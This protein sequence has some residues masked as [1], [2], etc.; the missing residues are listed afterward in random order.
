MADRVGQHAAAYAGSPY[1]QWKNVTRNAWEWKQG[2]RALVEGNISEYNW[3]SWT[4]GQHFT[5]TTRRNSHTNWLNEAIAGINPAGI[6]TLS[7]PSFIRTGD[8]VRIRDTSNMDHNYKLGKVTAGCDLAAC[9]S[10][11]VSDLP[12]SNSTGGYI[13][14]VWANRGLQDINIRWN[15]LRHSTDVVRMLSYE[16]V[17]TERTT[18]YLRR[19]AL[20]DNLIYDQDTSSYANGGWNTPDGKYAGNHGGVRYYY[21]LGNTEHNTVARNT[22]YGLKGSSNRLLMNEE[23]SVKDYGL[24]WKDDLHHAF[25]NIQTANT[26]A[27]YG[28]AALSRG[29]ENQTVGTNVLCCGFGSQSGTNPAGLKWPVV[30][31]NVSWGAPGIAGAVDFRL[32]HDS[33][34]VSGYE[35]NENCKTNPTQCAR[36]SHGGDIGVDVDTLDTKLGAV[37][38][39]RVRSVTASTAIVSYLAPDSAACPSNSALHR[40]GEQGLVPWTSQVI[41]C[42]TSSYP[43]SRR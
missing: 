11:T 40:N 19:V 30:I 21:S 23:S 4:H 26:D 42:A 28:T 39:V 17:S 37:K 29:W 20:T 16:G 27:V 25:G 35:G 43:A 13:K 31:A 7:T 22:V 9:N 2:H 18:A 6:V 41:A 5:L 3:T 8:V 1:S 32:R 33:R 10:I 15:L 24:V 36:A 14:H 34:F 38:N 12:A